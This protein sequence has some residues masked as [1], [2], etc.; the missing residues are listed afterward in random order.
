MQIVRAFECNEREDIRVARGRYEYEDHTRAVFEEKTVAK[1]V[2]LQIYL[3][4][5]SRVVFI[6]IISMYVFD[7]LF[8]W[9]WLVAGVDLL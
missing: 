9:L 5:F 1:V 3:I 6:Y 2:H 7:T 8:V 4:V